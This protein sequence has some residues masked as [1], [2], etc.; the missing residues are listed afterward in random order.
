MV[1]VGDPG[2][3]SDFNGFGSVGYEY[4]IG[5][6]HVTVS[7]YTEFL[8]TVANVSDPY[9]L[10][11]P[12]MASVGYTASIQRQS[13]SGGW[14]YSVIN[15][16]GWAG[17]RPVTFVTWFDAARFAN[18][19]TNGQG[20]GSTE[21]GAYELNGQTT[22]IAPTANAG[23]I[24]RLPTVNEWYKAGFWDQDRF[25]WGGMYYRYGTSSDTY[26]PGNVVGG[27]PN[28]ANY[29][30]GVYSV[31]QSASQ[32]W[33]QNYLTDVGAF[34]NSASPYGAFDMGSNAREWLDRGEAN[35]SQGTTQGAWN[36][37]ESF[38]RG[39]NNV[40]LYM[41]ASSDGMANGFRLAAPVPEP[42]TYAMA[43]A[44]IACGGFSIWRR[45]KHK[46]VGRSFIA[47]AS[48]A[49]AAA[50]L[51]TS[52]AYA[53]MVGLQI[54]GTVG[55]GP[56]GTWP[57]DS[58]FTASYMFDTS[59]A[60]Y[61]NDFDSQTYYI[62][63]VKSF[64]FSVGSFNLG[65]NTGTIRVR[66]GLSDFYRVE[67]S[68]NAATLPAGYEW[69]G[70]SLSYSGPSNILSSTALPTDAAALQL[71]LDASR[72]GTTVY[73]SLGS[74]GT[75]YPAYGYSSTITAVPEPAT[76]AMA[77]AGIACGGYSMWRRLRGQFI[78]CGRSWDVLTGDS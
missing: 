66:D 45:R 34:T 61:F 46:R 59:T 16:S 51:A 78:S 49:L 31:T 67:L 36:E 56:P 68:F 57:Q 2:N 32:V 4:Q 12:F 77:L 21:T 37:N 27:L 14:Q 54:S 9:S 41:S 70:L 22:G 1:T 74:G 17:N 53:E 76:Y 72:Y 19:M 33:G 69:G 43:L 39:E 8:N 10:Y 44:G 11:S 24:Y 28:Q 26:Y 75:G 35:A 15:N 73:P 13:V 63:A 25:F 47:T 62:G 55:Q 71:F 23:A 60:P 65:G 48:L 29:Y 50:C 20:S 7:Q 6:Y 42:S 64:L 18:W 3:R 52:P 30:N 58:P 5:K 40:G 38:I